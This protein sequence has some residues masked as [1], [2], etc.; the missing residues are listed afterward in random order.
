MLTVVT[1][2][3]SYDLVS[4]EAVKAALGIS[5][6]GEDETLPPLISAAS[7]A[8][9]NECNRGSF[10]AETVEETL[11]IRGLEAVL[12]SRYPVSEVVSVTHC[13]SVLDP[14]AYEVAPAYGMLI[15]LCG[16]RVG[17]WTSGRLVVRYVAGYNLDKVPAD[18]V[19]ATIML[20]QTY[21]ASDSRD[22]LLRAEEV[23]DIERLEYNVQ[24]GTALPGPVADL[25]SRHRKPAGA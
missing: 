18:L 8:I 25:I 12:L 20:V 16:D 21:R 5:G 4:V 6:S 15:R 17:F 24:S 10:I 7:T 1:P 23:G 2:A 11:F 13:G 14:S 3:E 19:R 22:P 9:T